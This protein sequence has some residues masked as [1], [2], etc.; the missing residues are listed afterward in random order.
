VN[1]AATTSQ[2]QSLQPAWRN[3]LVWAKA[4]DI[5]AVLIALSLPW[6]TSLVGILNVIWIIAV[7]PT[8]DPQE[9][10]ALVKRPICIFPLAL[11]VLALVGTLWSDAAWGVRLHA[12]SPTAKLLMLP[13]LFYHYARSER[14]IWVFKAFLISCAL[15]M[16]MSWI[17]AFDPG[18]TL[19]STT[20]PL[21]RGIFVKNYID[22][23]QEFV[24][25]AVVIAFPVITL[26]REQK[27]VPAL[28]L[29]ALALSFLVNMAFVVVS[30]TALVTM[31][32]M[33]AVF[34]LLHL[35]WRSIAVIACLIAVLAGVAW[36]TSPQLRKTV[37]TFSRDYRLYKEQNIPTSAGLRIEFWEKS[38]RFFAEA[39]I[40]GHGTGSTLGLFEQAAVGHTGA[41][42][43]VIGNPHN[44]TLNVAVQWGVIG[45]I[46]LYAMWLSHLLL[47]RGEGLM[48]WIG[49][50]V[51]VQNIF[52]SL[53]NSH[54]FDF[55]EGWMYVL[56]AGV[57]GGTVLQA[58]RRNTTTEQANPGG[59]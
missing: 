47:F 29:S 31:P 12:V 32:I 55:H 9:L 24:L 35:R 36:T 2:A 56:G 13:L 38:L 19:K 14:G 48:A 57:A 10:T 3:P 51:V 21:E 37:G 4:A 49:L 25:C 52:T 42:A 59:S 6:S 46:V 43:E 23:S 54:I 5:I 15:L 50:M 11:F 27:I 41:A 18:I 34:A 53:F 7:V 40:A 45:I 8:I 1:V 30:R 58:K 28:L 22:Q 20:D 17:V 33:L 44:Q 26:L 39:P 16:V